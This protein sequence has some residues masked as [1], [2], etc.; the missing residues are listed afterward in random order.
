MGDVALPLAAVRDQFLSAVDL[1][2]QVA[3]QP[4]GRRAVVA[5]WEVPGPGDDPAGRLLADTDGVL[6]A[7]ARR[8]RVL[9][10][11]GR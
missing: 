3:R 8:P 9:G 7:P 11:P 1:V 10:G 6:A 5:V 2:V 4:S